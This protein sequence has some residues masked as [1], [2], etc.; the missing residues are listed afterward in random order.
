[1]P[2][3]NLPEPEPSREVQLLR[4]A[5]DSISNRSQW[6]QNKWK[7]PDGG[8]CMVMAIQSVCSTIKPRRRMMRRLLRALDRETPLQ[9]RVVLCWLSSRQRLVCYNDRRMTTH[10]DV[11]G[12]FHRAIERLE[13]RELREGVTTRGLYPG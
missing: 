9:R 3:D 4:L 7:A 12:L 13:W 10:K 5:R 11:M 1:M 2:F 8:M 6:V